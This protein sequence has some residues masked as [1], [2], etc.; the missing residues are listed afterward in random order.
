M[1]PLEMSVETQSEDILSQTILVMINFY[2][3][4]QF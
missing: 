2:L 3:N 1:S 4:L